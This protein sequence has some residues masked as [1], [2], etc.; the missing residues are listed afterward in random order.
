MVT[1]KMGNKDDS[2]SEGNISTM[3]NIVPVCPPGL[4]INKGD[5]LKQDFSVDKFFIEMSVREGGAGLDVLRDDLGIYL[6]VLRSSMIELIN[7]DYAD[8]VNLSTNLVGLDQ[9]IDK[10]R[11][12]M[13]GFHKEIEMVNNDIKSSLQLVKTK[14]ARQETIRK[15]KER[16][17]NLQMIAN[18]L[19]KVERMVG[20]AAEQTTDT[21]ER[22]AADIN[23]LNF[24]IWKMKDAA[25]VK[26]LLPR[27]EAV[28]DSLN[29]WLDSTTLKAIK[30]RDISTLSRCCRIYAT[31]DRIGAA[32]NLVRI[33]IVRP[34]V[35][36]CIVETDKI[37]SSNI[38]TLFNSLLRI[39]PE[40]LADL[41]K[42]TT[43]G[44]KLVEGSVDGF[45][46]VVNSFWPEVADSIKKDLEHIT[47]PGNPN[48]F[49]ENY[50]ISMKFL[51]DFEVNLASEESFV[52][53]RNQESYNEFLSAWNL[54]VYF[55]IRFQD[56]AKPYELLLLK[57]ELS[58]AA[59]GCVLKVTEEA[60]IAISRCFSSEIFLQPL[61]HR[62]FKLALQVVSRYQ[63]WAFMC[64]KNFKDGP[65]ENVTD[66]KRS[67]TAK[68]LQKLEAGKRKMK[69]STSDQHL[70]D[71]EKNAPVLN[72][73]LKDLVS[74][75]C[76]I[77][78]LMDTVPAI[79][80]EGIKSQ[81]FETGGLDL[82]T[83]ITAGITSLE[84]VLPEIS[85]A[86]V[87]YILVSP[88]KLVKSVVDIPRMYRRTNREVPSKPCSYVTA[89]VDE[90]NAFQENLAAECNQSI[91]N[92]W[93][94][95]IFDSLLGL[96][97]IQVQDV[98]SNVT[99][100]EESLKKLKKVREKSSGGVAGKDK[101]AG[102]SDDD[103]IR[104]QLY[105]DVM[106]FLRELESKELSSVM[107]G[108]NAVNIKLVVE[109]SVSG[110]INEIQL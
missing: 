84:T 104:L 53:F 67:E 100:M 66:M 95:S 43:D 83:A 22:I 70:P 85:K 13:L 23:Q 82:N 87:D 105:L 12:P 6:K 98:L 57:T 77:A 88:C 14:L 33:N 26:Q 81:Q 10:I 50:K 72:I 40:Y 108:D 41:I 102:L 29:S 60:K 96:Y 36:N 91:I 90:I 75:Y 8:F 20:G 93:L 30:D 46:F 89:I 63:V 18:T 68:D 58:K 62:F 99:K 4:C 44:K 97:L 86:L 31:I 103:K 17:S 48:E 109:Q 56:I 106:Y 34:H 21:A 107:C 1:S 9:A 16:L 55:Q 52:R 47:S 94:I 45:D 15:D 76:D 35:Q 64:L 51:E 79:I 19:S 59:N 61:G 73:T 32:E 110:F 38:G 78:H 2:T 28:C 37:D 54:P 24:A 69:K 27:L 11:D 25:L 71:L 3:D 65:P 39:I 49:F 7:Q 5:F 74:I 42:L 101:S 80:T 92:A